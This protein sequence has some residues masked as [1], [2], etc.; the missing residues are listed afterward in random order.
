MNKCL[1]IL[2]REEASRN[3]NGDNLKELHNHICNEL[4]NYADSKYFPM[5]VL[6]YIAVGTSAHK[7]KVFDKGYLSFDEYKVNHVINMCDMFAHKFGDK[8]RTNDKVVHALSRFYSI[9][10]REKRLESILS[11]SDIDLSAI[12]FDSAKKLI[13]IIFKDFVEFSDKGYMVSFK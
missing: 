8:F 12:K 4:V 6:V 11:K 5:G 3:S 2:I 10:G 13:N 1:N 9:G 7:Q